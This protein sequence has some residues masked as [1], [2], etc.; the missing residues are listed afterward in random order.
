[1]AHYDLS[2]LDMVVSNIRGRVALNHPGDSLNYPAHYRLV[3][4]AHYELG[5]SAHYELGGSAHYE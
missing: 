3:G 2:D 4:S 5:E 1:M